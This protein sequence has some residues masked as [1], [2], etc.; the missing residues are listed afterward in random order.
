MKLVKIAFFFLIPFLS[1][2]PAVKSAD[3]PGPGVPY[4]QNYSKTVYQAG[5]KNWSVVKDA[6]GVMYF[7]NS[8]GLLSFD[9]RYWNLYRMPHKE[10]VRAVAAGHKGRIYGGGFGE[11]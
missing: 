10:I 9:G 3:L 7:G 1:G 11:F 5:N 6:S 2:I 4:V 8:G